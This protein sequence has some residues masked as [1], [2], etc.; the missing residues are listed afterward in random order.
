MASEIRFYHLE[1]SRLEDTLPLLLQKTL[2][3]G[4]KAVVRTGS[5][6]RTEMLNQFLWT[7]DA[8]SFLPHG[9]TRDGDAAL[10]PVW[11]TEEE[12]NP[13]GAEVLFLCDGAACDKPDAFA[14]ICT[15]FDGS[16]PDQLDHAR[17]QWKE[18]KS[19][20]LPLTYWQQGV[21]GWEKKI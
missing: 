18:W 10:H 15:I 8:A 9:S 7:Y 5:P 14:L 21:N 17:A 19:K 16:D 12:E 13:N 1:H 6:E 20:N 4:R 2:A 3:S 11:L